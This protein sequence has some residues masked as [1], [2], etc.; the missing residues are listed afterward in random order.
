M[1]KFRSLLSILCACALLMVCLPVMTFSASAAANNR[2][3]YF[4]AEDLVY[5]EAEMMVST[6]DDNGLLLSIAGGGTVGSTYKTATLTIP[7]ET[8]SQMPYLHLDLDGT[9]TANLTVTTYEAGKSAS[10]ALITTYNNATSAAYAGKVTTVNL[11][12]YVASLNGKAVT[13]QFNV[14]NGTNGQTVRVN[15]VYASS[16]ASPMAQQEPSDANLLHLLDVKSSVLASAT[17][18]KTGKYGATFTPGAQGYAYFAIPQATATQFPY[19]YYKL[20]SMPSAAPSAYYSIGDVWIGDLTTL[21][22]DDTDLHCVDLRTLP[23]Y[24]NGTYDVAF[25]LWW[26]D[27]SVI[28]M[29]VCLLSSTNDF[30]LPSASN[31]HK[32]T[33][34]TNGGTAVGTQEVANGGTVDAVVPPVRANHTFRGWYTDV[35]CTKPYDFGN[36]VSGDMTLYAGW[37]IQ[38][39]ISSAF[40]QVLKNTNLASEKSDIRFVATIPT[41][42]YLSEVGFVFS[43]SNS[44]PVDGGTN[45]TTVSTNTVYNSIVADGSTVTATQLG[46][47]YVVACSVKNIPNANFDTPI[48]VTA[49]AKSDDGTYTYGATRA[50]RV[51][52]WLSA[53]IRENGA[54]GDGETDDAQAL[55]DTI[56][57]VGGNGRVIVPAGNYFISTNIT[58]PAGIT[59]AVDRGAKFTVASGATLAIN[60]K[61]DAGMYQIFDGA[62]NVGGNIQ[63]EGYAQWFGVTNGAAGDCTAAL[64][65]AVNAL[66]HV[67]LPYGT[68]AALADASSSYYRFS[69]IYINKPTVIE[70]RGGLRTNITNGN[71]TYHGFVINSSDVTI[72][73]FYS[74]GNG[75]Q[76]TQAAM[77]HFNTAAQNL[78]NIRIENCFAYLA[79]HMIS[80]ANSSYSVTN[81]TLKGLFANFSY[82]TGIYLTD[83]ATGIVLDEIVA[84]WPQAG[85]NATGIYV[86]NCTGMYAYDLDAAMGH[87]IGAAPV[88]GQKNDGI[89]FQN[90]SNVTLNRA[91]VDAVGGTPFKFLACTNMDIKNLVPSIFD[92][93]GIMMDSVTNSTF[94]I[95]K[96]NGTVNASAGMHMRLCSNVRLN[97]VC[98][99][100]C[101]AGGF[102]LENSYNN[103]ITNL[104]TTGNSFGA[105]E[106][107]GMSYAN[108]FL[109]VSGQSVTVRGMNSVVYGVA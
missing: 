73:N 60:G 62:G 39:G 47:V 29:E 12:S 38:S 24:T 86:A 85:S 20:K 94:T 25:L 5:N 15:S 102:T 54:V 63:G 98:V 91:M 89:V 93:V 79:G 35:A 9:S 13:V 34:N 14:I 75:A 105:K 33:F 2:Y 59:L 90:C 84:D 46:G 108:T 40:A 80:D 68:G 3:H 70:G 51:S 69:T 11:S 96:V 95:I 43:L 42:S 71:G 16:S 61:I 65:K 57:A 37:T 55:I 28:D 19:F 22:Y 21:D 23:A 83:F 100:K 88:A 27:T 101:P 82:N 17:Y 26:D 48:Y 32:V 99:Q 7:Y 50:H 97:N 49:Y 31:G 103:V 77:Y 4:T 58:V 56:N 81:A 6:L 109:G 53:N 67:I 66:S 78:N 64:Q 18:E 104:Y 72:K 107:N 1:K 92:G 74:W 41:R 52:N 87:T 10:N 44:T 36:A 8:W 106:T 45:C 30:F 76:N